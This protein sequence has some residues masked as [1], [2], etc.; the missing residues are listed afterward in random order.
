MR[1]AVYLLAAVLTACSVHAVLAKPVQV[2]GAQSTARATS[3]LDFSVFRTQIEPIF[4]KK[5]PE[6][7]RCYVC[8]SQGT[9]WRLQELSPGAASWNEEQSRLNFASVQRLVVP[10]NPKA[11][12]LLRMPLVEEAGGIHFHPG[13][14]HWDSLD[15][16]EVK[17]LA[18]WIARAK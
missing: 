12:R 9:P 11:S 10:G 3:P 1:A 5:R 6:R 13:G 4:L 7:A 2:Q 18:A 17:I 14:K 15:D 8:H 16:P